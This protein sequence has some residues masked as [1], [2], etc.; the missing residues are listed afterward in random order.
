MFLSVCSSDP[1]RRM[2]TTCGPHH[3]TSCPVHDVQCACGAMQ[4]G[5]RRGSKSEMAQPLEFFPVPT[6]PPDMVTTAANPVVEAIGPH[7]S[8]CRHVFNFASFLHPAGRNRVSQST[9]RHGCKLDTDVDV[10]SPQIL[11]LPLTGQRR[12]QAKTIS[13]ASMCRPW[14]PADARYLGKEPFLEVE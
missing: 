7:F 6:M 8:L 4:A 9:R 12:L 2:Y 3:S 14:L 11:R 13:Q 5:S 10:H 1:R